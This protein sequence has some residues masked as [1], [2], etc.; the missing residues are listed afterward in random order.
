LLPELT[1]ICR[2][3]EKVEFD[4][5]VSAGLTRAQAGMVLQK[6]QS[7]RGAAQSLGSPPI[8][9]LAFG[10]DVI[11]E[12]D[13]PFEK[14]RFEDKRT[15]VFAR[16]GYGKSNLS[17]I[18]IA[19]ASLT[20]DTGLLV[21]D[22][23]GEYTFRAEKPD[24]STT[25]GLADIDLLKPRL[26]V[27]TTREDIPEDYHAV[28]I[29]RMVNLKKLSPQAIAN[30]M[31]E[32][33]LKVVQ[34]FRNLKYL[35][36]ETT[37]QDEQPAVEREKGAEVP[38]REKKDQSRYQLWVELVDTIA[39]EKVFPRKLAQFIQKW[40]KSQQNA[41]RREI[42]RLCHLHDSRAGDLVEDIRAEI[43]NRKLVV[44]DFS[45]LEMDQ[46]IR[47]ASSVLERI[48]S[49]NLWGVTL[50]KAIPVVAVFEEAQNVLNKKAVEEGKT[51]FVR[52]AKEG[53][54]FH[55]GLIYV[56][57]QPGA[58]AEEIVSQ[59]DNFFVM[60]LLNRNDID[61][62]VRANRHYDGVIAQFLGDETVV[63]NAYIYSAPRQPYVFPARLAEFTPGLFDQVFGSFRLKDLADYLKSMRFN[64]SSHQELKTTIP[65]F[66]KVV[67]SWLKR[68]NPA[69]WPAWVDQ[70][71]EWIDWPYAEALLRLLDRMDLFPVPETLRNQWISKEKPEEPAIPEE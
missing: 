36:Q 44:L 17:K 30:L 1:A 57:Q 59:T 62:L 49:Y 25:Y 42:I 39:D 24:G 66:S 2:C 13:I 38:K 27:Y 8:G 28:D 69:V 51:V 21:L 64:L 58:I 11:N 43:R 71:K 15:A 55:L 41:L 18:V 19:L 26:V 70:D 10:E 56:T 14:G 63:G 9:K 67:Y 61:A 4:L 23:D 53:R 45:L 16:T 29:R 46:A 6:A 12:V 7:G 3:P 22:I 65:A 52:W 47:I 35:D 34:E 50:N 68:Q 54:K 60:H 5:I 33:D 31:T 37:E 48:F 40:D 20:G 32:Q